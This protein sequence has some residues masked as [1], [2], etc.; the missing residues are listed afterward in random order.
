M[1][2]RIVKQHCHHLV[3]GILAKRRTK[4]CSSQDLQKVL[5]FLFRGPSILKH[6]C[7][8]FDV[9]S[10]TVR[11]AGPTPY[12]NNDEQDLCRLP[13]DDCLV[14]AL[15][16]NTVIHKTSSQSVSTAEINLSAER[17]CIRPADVLKSLF[18]WLPPK[19]S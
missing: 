8:C 6:C 1:S 15:V 2:V 7:Q 9:L 16:R 3:S 4:S 11:P 10:S 12:N 5:L 17:C 13:P 14:G 18:F 19:K